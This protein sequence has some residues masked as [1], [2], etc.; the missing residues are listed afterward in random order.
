MI[1]KTPL[2]SILSILRAK[3]ASG[4]SLGTRSTR[5]QRNRFLWDM[6]LALDVRNGYTGIAEMLLERS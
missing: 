4:F 5:S 3:R 6:V 1:H 2:C